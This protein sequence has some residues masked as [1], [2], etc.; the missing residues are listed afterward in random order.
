MPPRPLACDPSGSLPDGVTAML[1][2][3]ELAR[4]SAATPYCGRQGPQSY[5]AVVCEQMQ[6]W[7]P[8][9]PEKQIAKQDEPS[10]QGAPCAHD[11]G[12]PPVPPDAP[13]DSVPAVPPLPP[14]APPDPPLPPV[15]LPPWPPSALPPAP[16]DPATPPP[17]PA[18]DP[19]EPLPPVPPPTA[20]PHAFARPRANP[21]T[22][23][24]ESLRTLPA[25]W[26]NLRTSEARAKN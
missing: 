16:T 14:A 24:Y 4:P 20:D 3:T 7:V 13:P 17:V 5:V 18:P 26:S 6:L 23:R 1:L 2:N 25:G 12:A 9:G 10:E 15:A 11:A 21:T 19:P 8:L 22:T